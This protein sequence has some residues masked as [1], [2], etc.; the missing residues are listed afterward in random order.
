MIPKGVEMKKIAMLAVSAMAVFG[1]SGCN[2]EGVTDSTAHIK[3]E[4]EGYSDTGNASKTQVQICNSDSSEYDLAELYSAPVGSAYT[5]IFPNGTPPSYI[6]PGDC[7][8]FESSNCGAEKWKIKVVDAY[9]NVGE[10]TYYREC[11][12]RE[13]LKVTN[14]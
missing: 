1:L 9:D 12:W 5:Q 2:L 7:R 3:I 14:W 8:I 4:R 11:G 6:A 10:G 13:E